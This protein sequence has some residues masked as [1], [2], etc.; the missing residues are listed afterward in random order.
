MYKRIIIILLLSTLS[1]HAY[2]Y[3]YYDAAKVKV[4]KASFR[5]YVRSQAR[6]IVSE[7]YNI[8]GKLS[9]MQQSLTHVRRS[10]LEQE[11]KWNQWLKKCPLVTS[12][13]S[14]ELTQFYKR[15]RKLDKHL[16]LVQKNNLKK[17]QQLSTSSNN[18]V[19]ILLSISKELDTI[20]TLNYQSLHLIEEILITSGDD[21][22]ATFFSK[23]RFGP[24]LRMMLLTGDDLVVTQIGHARTQMHVRKVWMNFI[25][26]LERHI[27][28]NNNQDY[29]LSHLDNFNISWNSF[30]M[31]IKKDRFIHDYDMNKKPFVPSSVMNTIQMMHNRWNWILKLYLKN[32]PLLDLKKKALK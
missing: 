30:H 1:A 31:N 29:L 25:T 7:F 19:D 3:Y 20:S 10:I 15:A 4:G 14:K 16:L 18:Y 21:E 27:L 17:W 24:L 12:E 13:C 23:D 32:T 9:L 2:Q 28:V 22:K 8:I 5:R 11:V 26:K 6:N